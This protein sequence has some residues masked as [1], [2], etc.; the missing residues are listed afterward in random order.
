M[1]WFLQRTSFFVVPKQ[2]VSVSGWANEDD[3]KDE[4][5]ATDGAG[6]PLDEEGAQVKDHEHDMVVEESGVDGLGYE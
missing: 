3:G 4:D 5:Q 2:T 1:I 6:L